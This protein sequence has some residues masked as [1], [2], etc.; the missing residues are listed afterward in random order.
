MVCDAILAMT[1]V[2]VAT[3]FRDKYS[4]RKE[5]YAALKEY[6]GTASV[7][8]IA[9]RI[10]NENNM[11]AVTP[12]MAQRGDVALIRRGERDFSLGIIGLNG[13]EIIALQAKGLFRVP[14]SMAVQCWRV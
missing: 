14:L 4:T 12:L 3:A 7:R 11:Q 1:G 5:A 10:T 9:W 6:A 2:D 8:A 13:T